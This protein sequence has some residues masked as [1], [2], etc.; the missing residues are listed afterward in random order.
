MSYSRHIWPASFGS[1]KLLLTRVIERRSL[2]EDDEVLELPR[3]ELSLCEV[4]A[5]AVGEFAV[6]DVASLD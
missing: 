5:F 4:D 6:R 1:R 3:L 2:S